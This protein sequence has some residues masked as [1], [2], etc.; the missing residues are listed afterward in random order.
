MLKKKLSVRNAKIITELYF[1]SIQTKFQYIRHFL[2]TLLELI[3]SI[4]KM[5]SMP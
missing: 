2:G 4:E 5:E 3:K 1:L